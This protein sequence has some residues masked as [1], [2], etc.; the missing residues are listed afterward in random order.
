MSFYK[1]VKFTKGDI[2]QIRLMISSII[3]VFIII[4]ILLYKN[5]NFDFYIAKSSDQNI[6]INFDEDM[7]N[8]KLKINFLINSK[9]EISNLKAAINI[10]DSKTEYFDISNFIKNK[11]TITSTYIIDIKNTYNSKYPLDI[12]TMKLYYIDNKEL[13]TGFDINFPGR[14]ILVKKTDYHTYEI[15]F[16]R[17]LIYG[18][19]VIIPIGSILG[20][21]FLLIW[22]I[23]ISSLIQAATSIL[24]GIWSIRQIIALPTITKPLLLDA[25]FLYIYVALGAVI[26]IKF[27]IFLIAQKRDKEN[28]KIKKFLKIKKNEDKKFLR[29]LILKNNDL[30]SQ[31]KDIQLRNSS[32]NIPKR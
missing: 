17:P 28:K 7:I 27:Y 2:I 10:P 32:T 1:N 13:K 19:L 5:K 23:D 24:F 25:I 31:S 21:I 29:S 11:N 4:G 20:L 9:N 12:I 30:Q 6:K 16:S 15:G 26:S 14:R 18:Y 22:I 8:R 3:F